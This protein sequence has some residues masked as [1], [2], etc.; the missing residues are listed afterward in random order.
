MAFAPKEDGG[1]NL[2]FYESQETLQLF[3]SVKTWLLKNCKKVLPVQVLL[4]D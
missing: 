2:K 1:P 3:E 4:Y